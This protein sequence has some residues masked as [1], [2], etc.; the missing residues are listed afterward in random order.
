MNNSYFHESMSKQRLHFLL[1]LILAITGNGFAQ[2]MAKLNEGPVQKELSAEIRQVLGTDNQFYYNVKR[3][4]R[5]GSDIYLSKVDQSMKEVLDKKIKV[6]LFED[7]ERNLDFFV[8]MNNRIWA[9]STF[10]HKRKNSFILTCDE[11]STT[12]FKFI[13]TTKVVSE[14]KFTQRSDKGYFYFTKS[15]DQSKL[16]VY[17]VFPNNPSPGIDV[18][19]VVFDQSMNEIWKKYERLEMEGHY[20]FIK[21]CLVTNKGEVFMTTC[22][23]P[24]KVSFNTAGT[25]NYQYHFYKISNN[26]ATKAITID[27]GEKFVTEI[28][29]CEN[30]NNEFSCV[31]FYSNKPK[32][33]GN[34]ASGR[35]E[36]AKGVFNYLI[37]GEGNILHKAFNEFTADFITAS[38]GGKKEVD[39]TDPELAEFDIRDLIAS[40]E[41]GVFLIAEQFYISVNASSTT[42]VHVGAPSTTQGNVLVKYY[43]NDIVVVKMKPDG[44]NEWSKLVKKRQYDEVTH[45]TQTHASYA[46]SVIVEYL[47]S[48]R[49]PDLNLPMSE[50]GGRYCSFLSAYKDKSL[51]L[52]FNDN[53]ENSESD[54]IAYVK[55]MGSGSEIAF[56]AVKFDVD[57]KLERWNLYSQSKSS[58][59]IL[60]PAVSFM[61]NPEKYFLVGDKGKKFQFFELIIH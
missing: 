50:N 20:A 3:V 61:V 31:G 48:K 37:D 49:K 15:S 21:E 35:R 55:R 34:V 25:S 4:A 46:R 39:G 29:L 60:M 8:L 17:A 12:D 5:I 53:P 45:F 16:M 32:I 9:F 52:F 13:G 26:S 59:A 42:A 51:F 2:T 22:E 18:A 38:R 7:H 33:S 11:I 36:S 19:C 14:I 6:P 54:S 58:S 30:K 28:K 44:S 40:D 41:G 1:F 47:N 57:G 10:Q 43:F 24:D 56:T 23:Y 27:L